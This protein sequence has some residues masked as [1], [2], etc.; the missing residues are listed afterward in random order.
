[1]GT[2]LARQDP[3]GPWWELLVEAVED[4]AV[5]TGGTGL[6]AQHFVEW[7]AEWAR[8]ARR[9][10]RGLLLL[11]AHRAKGLEFDHVAVL[12]GSWEGL[13]Q[14]E[15]RDAPRRLYYVAMT[16]ARQTLS[17]ARLDLPDRHHPLL[18][19]L[20]ECAA[21]LR[22]APGIGPSPNPALARRYWLSSQ[23]DVDLGYAGRQALDAAPHRFIAALN[24]GDALQLRRHKGHWELMDGAGWAVGRM[25]GSWM[26]LAGMDCTSVRVWAIIRRRRE[27]TSEKYLP[28]VKA[29]TWEVVL[30]EMVFQSVPILS[31]Q[32]PP[33]G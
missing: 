29:D 23:A 25:A 30:P 6:P 13:G 28:L 20:P 15:D 31:G 17:L 22:R 21:L 16:R 18:D 7:L 9:R 19:V 8:E 10:Q 27:Q 1:M 2:W 3:P 33:D 12:D 5:E 32:I 14:N 11:T 4:Y 24:P 26:P